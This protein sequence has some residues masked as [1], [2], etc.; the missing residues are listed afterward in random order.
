MFV[1]FLAIVIAII[2][3]SLLDSS[4]NA[5]RC[6]E[7]GDKRRGF[8]IILLSLGTAIKKYID[9]GYIRKGDR[10]QYIRGMVYIKRIALSFKNI[11]DE[12][13]EERIAFQNQIQLV[14]SARALRK[15]FYLGTEKYDGYTKSFLGG[16]G[17]EFVLAWVGIDNRYISL[18]IGYDR[19]FPVLP[20]KTDELLCGY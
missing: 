20:C 13:V 1:I 14:H 17:V 12:D 15:T 10:F 18:T 9:R 6:V 7:V 3:I 4:P 16:G 11:I 8:E 19:G 2:A 5:N